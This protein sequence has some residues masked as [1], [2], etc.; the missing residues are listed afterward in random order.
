MGK[1]LSHQAAP[2]VCDVYIDRFSFMALL[3]IRLGRQADM[4]EM[5]FSLVSDA[6]RQPCI[7]SPAMLEKSMFLASGVS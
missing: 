7:P 6:T 1:V 5:P 4:V 3:D 2:R